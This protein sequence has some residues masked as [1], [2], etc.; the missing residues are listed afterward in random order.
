MS[1]QFKAQLFPLSPQQPLTVPVCISKS[2][3]G[4]VAVCLSGGGSRALTAGMGNL[5]ALE[6]L[7]LNGASLLSQ[8]KALSTVSG[9][10]WIG[11]PFTFLPP[12]TSDGNYLG[13][14]VD[15]SSWTLDKLNSLPA[16]NIG[17]Q[18]G[19]GFSIPAIAL[20]ALCLYFA[21]HVPEDMLW[22][23]VI[24]LH[25]LAPYGLFARSQASSFT[26]DSFFTCDVASRKAIDV[27]NPS[28]AGEKADLVAQVPQQARPYLCCNMGMFVTASGQTAL[29]PVQNTPAFTGIVGRPPAVD[30]NNQRVGGGGVESFGFNSQLL[31][32][33]AGIA[34]ISQSRQWSLVDAV[35]TS[36]AA[37]AATLKEIFGDWQKHPLHFAAAINL[38]GPVVLDFLEEAGADRA[39]AE[40]FLRNALEDAMQGNVPTLQSEV[41]LFTG[42]IPTYGYWPVPDS[43]APAGT[44]TFQKTQFADGGS[45]ENTGVGAMLAYDDIHNIISFVNSETTLARDE[46]GI[47]IVDDAIPPLFG[48]Q[49]YD[50]KRGYVLYHSNYPPVS[51]NTALYQNNQVFPAAMFHPLIEGLWNAS[52]AGKSQSSPTFCQTLETVQNDWFRVRANRRVRVLWVYLQNAAHWYSQLPWDVRLVMDGLIVFQNFPHY[53][54][55]NTELSAAEVNL[56]SNLAAWSVAAPENAVKFTAMFTAVPG[57]GA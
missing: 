46:S 56:M 52:G 15:P 48:F 2:T 44:S 55:L 11:V 12:A 1:G 51:D 57:G 54:T 33:T 30:A 28:L 42:L 38:H 34:T 5:Q 41:N 14:Y 31:S 35:G 18:I 13:T 9:G 10:S 40:V 21:H 7:Q 25:M 26:P 43:S 24:G 47:I 22:Q 53:N 45:L 17:S 39:L 37:F 4:D 27:L 19:K 50:S 16:G 8:V 29:A 36:S 6:K 32:P 20:K 49:P 3:P 23:T